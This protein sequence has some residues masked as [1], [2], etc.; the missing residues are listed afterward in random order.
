MMSRADR[1]AA[2]ELHLA[3]VV[4]LADDADHLAGPDHGHGAD[5]FLG[6]QFDRL[7]DHLFGPDGM[8]VSVV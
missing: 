2:L 6:H 7:D 4:P 5:V 8:D 3:G 1:G